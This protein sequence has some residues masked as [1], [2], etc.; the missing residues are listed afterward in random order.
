MLPFAKRCRVYPTGTLPP[1]AFNHQRSCSQ[2][3]PRT[4]RGF[5]KLPDAAGEMG[6]SGATAMLFFA[7]PS[8]S[9]CIR[10]FAAA[11]A[12]AS[13]GLICGVLV[14]AILIKYLSTSVT[15]ASN[16]SVANRSIDLLT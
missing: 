6:E 5:E 10:A 1:S 2:V 3:T 8:M 14:A 11:F 15:N 4:H 12:W 13:A 16:G 9:G 7:A